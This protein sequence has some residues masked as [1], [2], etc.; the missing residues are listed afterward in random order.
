MRPRERNAAAVALCSTLLIALL[1]ATLGAAAAQAHT[2]T[3]AGPYELEIGWRDEPAYSGEKNE[4]E[5][6]VTDAAGAPVRDLRGAL[7]V[8]VGFG[9]ARTELPLVPAGRGRLRAA[10]VP[11]RP[12]TYAL[13]VTGRLRERR[14]DVSV[15]CSQRTF[16]CVTGAGAIQFPVADPA[17]GQLAAKLDRALARTRRSADSADSAKTLATV[18]TGLAAVAIA[19]AAGLGL[20]LRRRRA[21]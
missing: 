13:H 7:T 1:A 9:G 2:R 3:S 17:G 14:V 11:T 6:A 19:A 8:Q 18:A 20:A 16:D 4:V 5:V 15:T 21:P 12:G 10:I